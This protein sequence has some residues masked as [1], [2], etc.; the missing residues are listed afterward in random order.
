MLLASHF[1]VSRATA[2][3]RLRNL[4]LLKQGEELESL[5]AEDQAGRGRSLARFLGPPEP[6]HAAV[7]DEFRS[8]FLSLAL[9]AYRR[10]KISLGKLRELARQVGAAPGD[11]DRH[12]EEGGGEEIRLP[13]GIE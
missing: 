13:E 2:L 10:E 7:R 3:Y 9:E 8:R 11:V 5:L 6:D 1:G 4:Q 12:L